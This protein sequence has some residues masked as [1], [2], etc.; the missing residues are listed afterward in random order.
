MIKLTE[1]KHFNQRFILIENNHSFKEILSLI[2]KAL[3]KNEPSIMAGKTILTLGRLFDG[4]RCI[5]SGNEQMI[6]KETV[7]AGLDENSY[8]NDRI[9]TTLDYKFISLQDTT[10]FICQSYL[11]DLKN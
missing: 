6:T 11:N 2:H 1:G 7:I 5:I 9:K 3:G 10:K 8:K 4:I